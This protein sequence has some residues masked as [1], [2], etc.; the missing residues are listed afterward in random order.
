TGMGM[1]DFFLGVLS[2]F[3]Q[4]TGEYKSYRNTYPGL[5]FQD[6]VKASRRLTLNLGVRWEGAPP[7]HEVRGRIEIFR[8]EDYLAK[9]KTPQFTNAP[10][11]ETFRGDPGAA[12]D[13][14]KGD[15]N[16]WAGR[17]GFA[18]DVF[19]DGK[20]SLRGGA[21]M[22]YD[23]HQNGESGNDAVN[24]AP[25]NVRLLVTQPQG[26]FSDPYRGR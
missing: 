21:G 18:W 15:F 19:G 7:Y 9:V 2:Q 20:T 1:A 12:E 10:F 22:F 25:W 4:G 24:F 23:Q 6:D 14:T 11:G 26:P 3:E 13:G 17:V 16:N 8:I 5:Y